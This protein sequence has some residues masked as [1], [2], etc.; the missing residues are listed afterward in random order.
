MW[1]TPTSHKRNVCPFL[2]SSAHIIYLQG[3]S[4]LPSFASFI[5]KF[6]NE[7]AHHHAPKS[8]IE[9][10]CWWEAILE[11]SECSHSLK[12]CEQL[13]PDIWVD[14]STSWGIGITFGNT[15]YA[16]ALSPEWKSDGR[17]IGWA[18]SITLEMAI[19][20]LIDH[21]FSDCS[22]IIHGNNTSVIGACREQV[23]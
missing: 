7:F 20:I 5:T 21:K 14:A 23:F 3:C 17:D 10:L 18:E 22:V 15:W 1:L 6:S 13:N 11:K 8:V 16:W 2:A 4:T 19:Y 12:P 9:G